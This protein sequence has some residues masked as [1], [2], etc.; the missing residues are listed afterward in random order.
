MA[1]NAATC[2]HTCSVP[3]TG[4]L[5]RQLAG[6]AFYFGRLSSSEANRKLAECDV[7]T[8]LLRD[9]S[10]QR[11]LF[12]L[13]VQTHRGPT[14]VRL[15]RDDS[16]RFRLD[17]DRHQRP[18]M[19]TFASLVDLVRFYFQPTADRH[20][21]LVD[22]AGD[23]GSVPVRLTAPLAAARGPPTLAHLA[24]LSIHRARRRKLDQ[25]ASTWRNDDG[26]G[27]VECFVD[28]LP[29][30]VDDKAKDFLRSYPFD[31]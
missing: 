20:C 5:F 11:F 31:L 28:S 21:V 3:S 14:S 6:C 22:S 10:D 15:A 25:A 16:G 18:A 7:G 30:F 23:A 24:R 8:F 19:P 4:D 17:C 1:P 9:S 2:P 12:A 29:S 27:C 13:S 26:L